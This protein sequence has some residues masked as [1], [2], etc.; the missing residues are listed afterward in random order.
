M[1]TIKQMTEVMLAFDNGEEIECYSCGTWDGVKNPVWNWCGCDYR[2]KAKPK[3]IWINEYSGFRHTL[4]ETRED[5]ED[6]TNKDAIRVA[7][8]YVEAQDE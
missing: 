4:Y 2:I 8:K 7:V 6:Y 5:A 3:T 1:K